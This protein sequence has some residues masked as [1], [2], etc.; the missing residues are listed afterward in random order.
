M[1]LHLGR[2]GAKREAEKTGF[3]AIKGHRHLIDVNAIKKGNEAAKKERLLKAASDGLNALGDV[4]R[5]HKAKQKAKQIL[6]S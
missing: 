2:K 1:G 6:S 5:N 4:I 3:A